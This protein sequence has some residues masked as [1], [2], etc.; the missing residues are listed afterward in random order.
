MMDL[1]NG[2]QLTV[3]QTHLTQR[4]LADVTVSDPFPGT[5]IGLVDL[6]ITLILVVTSA[7]TGSV[8]LAVLTVGEVGTSGVGTG[9]LR[10]R[11]HSFTSYGTACPSCT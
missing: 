6:W 10:F 1:I 7:F 3:L 9:P 5:T 2:G 4:V 11:W 8:Y